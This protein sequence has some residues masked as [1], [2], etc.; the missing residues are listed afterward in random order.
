MGRFI[1]IEDVPI[2]VIR[3]KGK[4]TFSLKVDLKTGKELSYD[5]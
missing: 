5:V 3:K 1:I 4:K 2:E